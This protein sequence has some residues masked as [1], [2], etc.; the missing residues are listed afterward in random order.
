MPY[1]D[2]GD[3]VVVKHAALMTSTLLSKVL[4]QPNVKLFN[5]T[6]VEDLIVRDDAVTG[7]FLNVFRPLFRRPLF[8]RRAFVRRR[9]RRARLG[10]RR[11]CTRRPPA[12]LFC[13]CQ[14]RADGTPRPDGSAL[15]PPSLPPSPPPGKRIGGVVT[16]WTLVTLHHDTQSCMDPNVLEAKVVVSTC[17]H[18]GP[19]GAHSVKRLAK[20]GMVRGCCGL[21]LLRFVWRDVGWAKLGMVRAARTRLA[22]FALFCLAVF[23]AFDAPRAGC[24]RRCRQPLLIPY[25]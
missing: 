25:R 2:D 10:A 23:D 24:R 14:P 17:G 1:E 7:G 18:D 9:R 12:R 6:A 5:A 4:Q 20:L 22:A 13:M 19:M 16:N 11:I 3:Y 8:A 15:R 21:D